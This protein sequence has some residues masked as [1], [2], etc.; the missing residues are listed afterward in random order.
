MKTIWKSVL[1][2]TDM[3]I[4]KVPEGAI[5]LSTAIQNNQIC[6]W[7][8]VDDRAKLVGA[9]IYIFGTGNPIPATFDGKFIGTVL[10]HNDM[11][12]WHIYKE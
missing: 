3:Q 2:L 1:A 6:I 7:Y 9:N 4:I 11:F 10:M 12:A 8:A 5:F